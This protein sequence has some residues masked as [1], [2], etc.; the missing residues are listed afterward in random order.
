[1][2]T[3]NIYHGAFTNIYE[4]IHETENRAIKDIVKD[5]LD[6]AVVFVDG[7]R[8]DKNYILKDNEL[9]TI[10]LFPKAPVVAIVIPVLSAILYAGIVVAVVGGA[11]AL[12]WNKL[13]DYSGNKKDSPQQPDPLESIPQLRGAKN[14][15]GIDKPFPFVMGKHLFTPYYVGKPYTT[16]G[17]E[18][19]KEQYFHA[20]FILGYSKIEV[21]SIKF[22]EIDLCSNNEIIYNG[23][24]NPDG[25]FSANEPHLELQQGASEVSLYSQKVYE[26][27]LS[28]ELMNVSGEDNHVVRFSAKNPQKVQIEFTFNNGLIAYNNDGSKRN[29]DVKIKV[30]WRQGPDDP[31][32]WREFGR[33]GTDGG[34]SPTSYDP[35][36]HITTITRQKAKVMRFVAEK[37]F[38]YAEIINV[39]GR[40]VELRI[41]R[42]TPDPNDTRI[43]DTVYL[44]AIRTW[45]F[46]YEASTK[47][48]ITEF[49]PQV[50]M[51]AKDRDRTC[52]LG[53]RLKADERL[54]GMINALN[55]I[56]QSCGR[57][58]NGASWTID[59]L[60]ADSPTQN[61][62]SIALK[63]MQ[64]QMLGVN[65]YA[66]NDD[67]TNDKIDLASFGEFYEWCD[68]QVMVNGK[69]A[70]PFTCNGVLTAE[71][72][73]DEL[74][75]VILTTGRGIRILIGS[76][77]G[78][79]ID[80]PRS[81]PLTILNSQNVLEANNQK[82]F[83]D[84]PDGYKIK[85]IDETDG[86]QENELYAMKDGG[87]QPSPDSVIENIEMPFVTNL[88]QVFKNGLYR[89]ACRKLRPEVWKRKLSIDGNLLYIGC[90]V[91][92]QDDTILVGIGEGAEIKELVF[93]G[94]YIAGIKTDGLFDV[95]DMSQR[96]GVKI[97]QFDGVNAHV[98]RTVE[99]VIQ[100]AGIYSEFTFASSVGPDEAPLP[101][102]GDI[103]SF[104]IFDRITTDALC[105]GKKD[106]GDGT[107]DV[108][109]IPY[110]EGVYTADS[111]D[112]P[113]FDSKLTP[114]QG[115]AISQE[116]PSS[117]ITKDELFEISGEIANERPTYEEIVNG[118]TQ[119][120]ATVEPTQLTLAATGGFRFV[121]LSWA[122]QPYLSNLM[123]YQLQVS[124]N[125]TDWYAPRFDGIDWKGEKD[126]VFPT[127]ATMVVH[128]NIP[129]AGTE[130]EPAGRFLYY[131]VRQRTMLDLYSEWSAIT[132]TETKLADTADYGVNSISANALKTAELFALFAHIGNSLIVDPSGMITEN[133]EWAEGDTR[134]L[135]SAKE[136]AFQYFLSQMWQTMARIG[137]EG[138]EASQFFSKDKFFLTNDD[139][140]GRR[141]KGYDIGIPYLSDNSRVVHYDTDML[142]QNG[143]ALFTMSGTGA[144]TG[145]G[146]GIG[147]IVKATAPYATEARALYG[148]FRLQANIGAAST[149]TLDFWVLYKWNEGQVLF[150]VGN[151]TEHIRI[152]VLNDEPYLNDHAS[153]GIWLNDHTTD[154]VWFNEIQAAHTRIAHYLNG[155][156][157]YVT[158][159]NE[160]PGFAANKW[161]HIGIVHTTSQIQVL[162]NNWVF[163]FDSQTVAAPVLIDINP[164]LGQVDDEHSAM[165]IDEVLLDPSAAES[166]ALF[167]QNTAARRPWGKLDDQYPWFVFNVKDPD[168]FRT[169]IFKSPD[170]VSAVQE[171]INGGT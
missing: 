99:V 57:T 88:H 97:T 149:F 93:D 84:L 153:D 104:G 59:S 117:P 147:L 80:K 138:V 128:P 34:L 52:R 158:I 3:I 114:P 136:I 159:E 142:D 89:Y 1:M 6:N 30:E 63:V 164:T 167:Y 60:D 121:A 12:F 44:T 7:F 68:G 96:Y 127:A 125:T 141:S 109:L 170:F 8:K 101:S 32:D 165:L 43:S 69:Q 86:Y 133:Q 166:P 65:R 137:L 146:E 11:A 160:A 5:D 29:A 79:L 90:L 51:I 20:L 58:W 123:E 15:S 16:I 81:N 106:N 122:K 14:Q 108:T 91:E 10:R 163:P 110:A 156:W 130:E 46:D 144:L 134:A 26:E 56:V 140:S 129:P 102:V 27:Q 145:E 67:G 131:R 82:N 72:R 94:D 35:A 18:D 70:G 31:Q 148:N 2:S 95:T 61:P 83:E 135:L 17:G 40:T 155:N 111:G 75:N 168:Y 13:V 120:G 105:F 38:S 48:G 119:A 151:D 143:L 33:I 37:T 78:I 64:S 39:P 118:F 4:T 36:T 76:K 49:V 161:Y 22:G 113:E 154:G 47:P 9:C 115:I 24:L 112:I 87:N 162:I 98:I 21:T 53:I 54:S 45:C 92:V 157:E 124:E 23:A 171:I 85:F 66:D 55:C 139:M 103:I 74:L 73:L 126:A 42:M 100:Q 77:Y 25:Q 50:P 41:I 116:I 169:N 132:G 62:A 71:K 152:E 19:G 28:I 150:D 107:F